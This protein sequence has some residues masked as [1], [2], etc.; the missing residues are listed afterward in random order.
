MKDEESK[1]IRVFVYGTLKSGH[2]NWSCYFEGNQGATL[3][4]RCY[5]TG[6][7]G[8]VDLGFFP[9]AVKT[10]DGV[11]R[12]IVGEVYR[13]DSTTLDALDC[14]EGHPDWY[15]REQVDTPWKRAWCYFMAD[16][17]NA[18]SLIEPGIWHPSDEEI[19]WYK[20]VLDTGPTPEQTPEE[21]NW[22]D[23]GGM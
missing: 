2:G 6:H 5:I 13:V 9:C 22:Q 12:H 15:C 20:G 17:N 16:H 21:R 1:G 18:S 11:E 10:T 3:L 14:L 7:I 4:G 8:L 23:E 19:L